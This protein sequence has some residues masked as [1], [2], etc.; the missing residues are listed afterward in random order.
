[1]VRVIKDQSHHINRAA[2]PAAYKDVIGAPYSEFPEIKTILRAQILISHAA[3]WQST[4]LTS[5]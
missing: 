1:M 5:L 2:V 4:K 3:C